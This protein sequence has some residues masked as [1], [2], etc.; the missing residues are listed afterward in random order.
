MTSSEQVLDSPQDWVADHIR[1]YVETD[2]AEGH[3]WQPGVFTLLLTTRGRRSG[4]LRRTALIYGRDGDA[5]LVVASQGGDPKHPAWYLNLLDEPL[6]E[7]QVGGER[8]TA[9]AR[10]ATAREK[11]R[12]WSTMA[13]AWPAYDDYQAKTDREIP[14]VVLERV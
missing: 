9:R 12:M 13:A 8:F 4:K 11:P 10:T 6:V 7:V 5:Y 2:G 3:E 14:V 1:R